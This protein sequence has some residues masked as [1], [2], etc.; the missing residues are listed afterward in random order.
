MSLTKLNCDVSI[1]SMY[2]ILCSNKGSQAMAIA[3]VWADLEE[4]MIT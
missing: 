2:G 3:I 4:N 1:P